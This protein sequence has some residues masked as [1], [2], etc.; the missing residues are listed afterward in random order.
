MVYNWIEY[1]FYL[2][3]PSN[4]MVD[5]QSGNPLCASLKREINALIHFLVICCIP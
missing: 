3:H 5:R 2:S 1:F 4:L